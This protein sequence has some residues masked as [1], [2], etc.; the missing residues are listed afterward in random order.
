MI[1][2][3]KERY[4]FTLME[5]VMQFALEDEFKAQFES[6]IDEWDGDMYDED[7]IEIL[8]EKH[9]PENDYIILSHP[10]TRTN[11]RVEFFEI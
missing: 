7:V 11:G 4:D 2:E 9:R 1:H 6:P 8:L 10:D 5:F 3:I